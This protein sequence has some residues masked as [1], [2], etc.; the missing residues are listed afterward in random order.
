MARTSPAIV[1]PDGVTQSAPTWRALLEDLR[2][3]PWNQH[4][5]NMQDF[6]DEMARRA[7]VWY[8][9][10][11]VRPSSPPKRF[12]QELERAKMLRILTD[13]KYAPGWPFCEK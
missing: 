7:Y 4:F 1:W 5:K 3:L 11:V 2:R 9:E 10:P 6:K 13:D 8:G 12:F